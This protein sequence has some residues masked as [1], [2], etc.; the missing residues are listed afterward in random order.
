[1]KP[2]MQTVGYLSKP[3]DDGSSMEN[4]KALQTMLPIKLR[5]QSPVLTKRNFDWRLNR[6]RRWLVRWLM[7]E[8]K[9][10]R[11]TSEGVFTRFMI[12]GSGH[13]DI[14]TGCG[15]RRST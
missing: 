15:R 11:R 8:R 1:M 12:I 10:T 3:W 14:G 7:A 6:P 13:S 5:P 9:A 4:V 2:M